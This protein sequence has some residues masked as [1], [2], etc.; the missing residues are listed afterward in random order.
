[1]KA[2]IC[3]FVLI[4]VLAISGCNDGGTQNPIETPQQQAGQVSLSFSSPPPGI[5]QVVARITRQGFAPREIQLN[6][7]DSTQSATGGFD[8]V[9]AGIWHLRVTALNDSGHAQ[10][11]GETD[12]NVIPGQT[13]SITLHLVPTSGGIDI[14]VTW[15]NGPSGAFING[16][17]EIG[18]WVGTYLPL[19]PGSTAIQGWIVT[20]GAIDYVTVWSNHHGTKGI[21][22]NATPSVGGIAQAFATTAGHTYRVRFAFAGNPEGLPL[23][24][25][26]IVTA[27]GQ[28]SQFTFDVTGRSFTNMG[29][30]VMTWDF[31]ASSS[32][33]TLEFYNADSI[34]TSY[35][36]AIDDVSVVAL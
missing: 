4:F 24:K 2:L 28:S 34:S 13:A 6:I 23:V 5:V 22:L 21:D 9:P 19:N 33:T 11:A 31:I 7:S 26:M 35:G 14:V 27:A 8:D 36:P 15:G 3:L 1:M 16:S 32:Q 12:V 29:W 25:T 18:P 17:F 30:Q 20:R 10:Y